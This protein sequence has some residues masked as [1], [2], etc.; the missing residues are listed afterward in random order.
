M[1][2]S[3][4]E[5]RC[6]HCTLIFPTTLSSVRYLF[7]GKKKNKNRI[8]KKKKNRKEEVSQMSFLLRRKKRTLLML[9]FWQFRMNMIATLPVG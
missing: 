8:R 1:N 9:K 7:R 5:V 3:T 6:M 4:F 2:S